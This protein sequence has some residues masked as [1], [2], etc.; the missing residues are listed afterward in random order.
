MPTL[1]SYALVTLDD[2]KEVLDITGAAEDDKLTNLINRATDIIEKY[3]KIG[4]QQ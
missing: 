1:V 3:C 4:R 2:T